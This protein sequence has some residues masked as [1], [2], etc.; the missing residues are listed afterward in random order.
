MFLE[1]LSN[2][3]GSFYMP[4]LTDVQVYAAL[5]FLM[6]VLVLFLFMALLALLLNYRSRLA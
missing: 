3:M 1:T 2:W 5:G 6:A 4:D